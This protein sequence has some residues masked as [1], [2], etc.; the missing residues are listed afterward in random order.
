MYI[1]ENKKFYFILGRYWLGST[2]VTSYI[3]CFKP[4]MNEWKGCNPQVASTTTQPANIGQQTSWARSAQTFS[5]R[6]LKILFDHPG[7]NRIFRARC[8]LFHQKLTLQSLQISST[9]K[10]KFIYTLSCGVTLLIS[11]SIHV[12]LISNWFT[13]AFE[14]IWY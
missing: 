8:H 9:F 14:Y 1:T 2:L 11:N 4:T 10:F 13:Q 5:R 7:S 6:P 12:S 3:K